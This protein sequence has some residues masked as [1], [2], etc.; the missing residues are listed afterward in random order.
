VRLGARPIATIGSVLCLWAAT[1]AASR[2]Q[3]RADSLRRLS[4]HADSMLVFSPDDVLLILDT[5]DARAALGDYDGA[6][7]RLS[8]AMQRLPREPQLRIE[9]SAVHQAR[10][11][12]G[13]ARQVLLDSLGVMPDEPQL[14]I[15]LGYLDAQTARMTAAIAG[16]ER[17]L[18]VSSSPLIKASAHLG[19]SG[20]YKREG[21]RPLAALH[22]SMAYALVPDLLEV[23][24]DLERRNNWPAP[25]EPEWLK[26]HPNTDR[27]IWLAK[28]RAAALRSRDSTRGGGAHG[29]DP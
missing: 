29:Q 28:N 14:L 19:L 1:A 24:R 6:A 23:T 7:E 11:R 12:F 20:V 5:A 16:F 3:A 10:L 18:A 15:A 22:D 9:L 4:L 2:P 13:L 21:Q 27:R 25:G 17:A 8:K 26:T